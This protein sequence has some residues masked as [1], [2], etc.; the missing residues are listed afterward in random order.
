MPDPDRCA[1]HNEAEKTEHADALLFRKGQGTGGTFD[2][3]FGADQDDRQM[4]DRE[5]SR[6]DDPGTDDEG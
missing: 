2:G 6:Q 4:P 3:F 1:D 5:V